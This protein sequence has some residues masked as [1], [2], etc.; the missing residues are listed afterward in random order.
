VVKP[1]W[2]ILVK[3]LGVLSKKGQMKT[4][5]DDYAEEENANLKNQK[6]LSIEEQLDLFAEL[7]IDQ[8]LNSTTE[9]EN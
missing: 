5:K 8:L 1:Y 7:I 4:K 2:C 9:N 6:E 3:K